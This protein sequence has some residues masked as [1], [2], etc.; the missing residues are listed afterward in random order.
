[1]DKIKLDENNFASLKMRLAEVI[2]SQ[3]FA[4]PKLNYKVAN[5]DLVFHYTSLE[6]FI[7]IIESQSFYFT[8]LNYL[9]D[10]KEYHYGVDIIR[11]VIKKYCVT[12][13]NSAI[14]DA[15]LKNIK[16]IYKSPR[17]ITCFSKNGDLLSQWRAYANDGKG[18]AVGFKTEKLGDFNAID[19]SQM[20]IEYNKSTQTNVI[21]E[22]VTISLNYFE[23]TKEIFDWTRYDYEYLIA[24]TI[25]ETL[26]TF[27]PTF[28]HPTFS[29]E[30]EFR[31][32]YCIDGNMN[33]IEHHQL[34]FR[35]SENLIIPF[36]KIPYSDVNNNDSYDELSNLKKKLPIEKI[37]IGPS[38]NF[39]LNYESIQNLLLNYGYKDVE[40]VQSEI[41]YRL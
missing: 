12:D 10:S 29:E 23:K 20:N 31:I 27:I 30:K 21:T 35:A 13:T 11:D 40:I 26:E 8:N 38:L 5:A 7:S 41:P 15:V 4:N 6:K 33:K 3:A 1:M 34:M 32:E 9:N 36:L 28:K 39:D 16:H 37:I 24:T 19:I 17:Y 14:L 18:I 22:I 25:I 2:L